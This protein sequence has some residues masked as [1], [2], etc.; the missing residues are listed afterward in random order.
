MR[1]SERV[2]QTVRGHAARTAQPRTRPS[3]RSRGRRPGRRGRDAA[4]ERECTPTAPVVDRDAPADEKFI[5][6]RNRDRAH[7]SPSLVQYR[8]TGVF[9]L[10]PR[11]GTFP[12]SP[13]PVR[14]R[15][16]SPPF[17]LRPLARPSQALVRVL[18]YAP[19]QVAYA[20]GVEYEVQL[21]VSGREGDTRR[22]RGQDSAPTL[23]HAVRLA[24]ALVEA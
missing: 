12:F 20:E 22:V 2:V 15:D 21:A 7:V 19:A 4:R 24:P 10:L 18:R 3:T 14:R 11:A 16:S 17:V 23:R 5:D 8:D 13:S 1:R 9:L 6:H